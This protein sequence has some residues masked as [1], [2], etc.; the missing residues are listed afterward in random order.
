MKRISVLLLCLV[1]ALFLTACGSPKHSG[2]VSG[3]ENFSVKVND[4]ELVLDLKKDAASDTWTCEDTSD[5][6]AIDNTTERDDSVEF[7]ITGLKGGSDTIVFDHM[8]D[9]GSTEAYNLTVEL[10]GSGKPD[11]IISSVSFVKAD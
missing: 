2:F 7:R 6:F 1:L 10:S 8:S 3:G 4:A 9:D 5:L 11:L